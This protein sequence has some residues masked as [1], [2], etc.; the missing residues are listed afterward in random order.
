MKSKM[1]SAT[2]SVMAGSAISKSLPMLA[3]DPPSCED[4]PLPAPKLEG[5]DA[6]PPVAPP[7]APATADSKAA[8]PDMAESIIGS[9]FKFNRADSFISP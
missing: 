8:D 3:A 1:A 7:A 2:S 4:E 6:P 9:T 5:R